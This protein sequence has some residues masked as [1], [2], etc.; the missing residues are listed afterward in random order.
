[1][2]TEPIEWGSFFEAEVSETPTPCGLFTARAFRAGWGAK[3]PSSSRREHA[4]RDPKN[5]LP[6]KPEPYDDPKFASHV[7]YLSANSFADG[8]VPFKAND[9]SS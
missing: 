9:T 3:N 4:P 5:K 2:R 8:F 6:Q 1:M 7:R